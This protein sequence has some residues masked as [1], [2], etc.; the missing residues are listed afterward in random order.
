MNDLP[1]QVRAA[2]ARDPAAPALCFEEHWLTWGDLRSF[3]ES[4]Q[5]AL[6]AAG[7]AEDAAIAFVPRTRPEAIAALLGLLEA[8]RGVRM[9]YAF[10]SAEA[11]ARSIARPGIGAVILHRVDHAE[12]ITA[13]AAQA[14]IAV[15]LLDGMAPPAVELRTADRPQRAGD[16]PPAQMGREIEILTSGTTG[17]PKHFAVPYS[18]IEQHFVSTPLTR[19]QGDAA[20]APP[21]LMYFPLGNITGLYSTLPTL[22]RGQRA[23]VLERFSIS[24]WHAY[25]L[26]HRPQ[27]AGVPPNAVRQI[28]EAELP[29]ADLASIRALGV[30]AA[31]LD[32][33]VHDA[34]ERRYAIPILL[35]YG[36]TEF[37]GPVAMMTADLHTH[38]GQAKRGSV[39]KPLPGAALRVVDADTGQPLQPGETGLLEVVSPRIGSHWIRTSDVALID[40][41]GFL[42][43]KGRADGAIMR[44]G[45]KILPETIESALLLHPGIAEAAV[46][47]IED[48]RVGQVPAA[49]ICLADDPLPPDIAEIEAH[50]RR[51][52]L[53]TQIPSFWEICEELPRTPSLKVDKMAVKALFYTPSP[54]QSAK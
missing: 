5:C 7:V 44:G 42:F 48:A 15:L 16:A 22:L 41:D 6:Q 47:G 1:A 29:V 43:L 26:E 17:P 40:E 46:V 39:G 8:G 34:F 13:A 14:G 52:L 12:Q 33:Q 23:V 20:A 10:Q 49:A 27:H 37:A 11:I 50:L 9:V 18:L 2:L 30:G 19:S 32:P 53:A 54:E 45:F 38:W 36:A 3:A 51:H 35:S 4:V 28:L 25:V 21:F 31:P 24:A